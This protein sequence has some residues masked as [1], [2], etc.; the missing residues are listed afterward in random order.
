MDDEQILELIDRLV[1]EEQR[2]LAGGA[3]GSGLAGEDHER[4]GKV[5]VALD[6]AWDLLRQRRA[7]EEFGLDPDQDTSPRPAEVV[8]DYEQ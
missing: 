6:R 4:L 3:D 5:T 2:L 1:T 7:K 8:E